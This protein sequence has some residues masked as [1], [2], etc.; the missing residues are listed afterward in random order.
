MN[1]ARSCRRASLAAVVLALA[2]A[3]LVRAAPRRFTLDPQQSRVEIHVGKTGLFGFAGHEHQVVSGTLHGSATVDLENVTASTVDLTIDAA[4][5]RVTG[6]GEPAGDVPKVQAAMVGPEC[7]DAARFP[8]IHFA[9]TSVAEAGAAAGGE[10]DLTVRGALTLHG[11]TRPLTLRVHLKA[12]GDRLQA[13]GQTTLRQTEFGIT[14]ISK[15]GVV[16]VKNELT[17]DWRFAGAAR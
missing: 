4:A 5:L 3:P 7:L 17:I 13:T 10:R 1:L 11:V 12:T 6:Q 9:S 8:T 15:A 2:A 16:K 14:P